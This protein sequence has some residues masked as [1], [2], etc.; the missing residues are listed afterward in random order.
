[1]LYVDYHS[2]PRVI[3]H[4]SSLLRTH[5]VPFD[6]HSVPCFP[7]SQYLALLTLLCIF[8]FPQMADPKLP[9]LLKM[10]LW[11]QNQLDEKAAYPRINDLTTAEL[12]DPSI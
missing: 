1:M 12:Q 7:L 10:L 8:L 9:S 5:K 4:L 6:Y 2:V 3:I 11:T